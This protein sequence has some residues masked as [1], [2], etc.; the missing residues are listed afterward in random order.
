MQTI[1]EIHRERPYLG[2]RRI[3]DTLQDKQF[4]VN[5]KRV[6]RLMRLMVFQV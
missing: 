6:H 5:R 3:T 2:V 1:D 4:V